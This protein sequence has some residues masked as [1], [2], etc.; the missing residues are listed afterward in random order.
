MSQIGT[1][2]SMTLASPLQRAVFNAASAARSA[3]VAANELESSG[4]S[5]PVS[6]GFDVEAYRFDPE[7]LFA[8]RPQWLPGVV[9]DTNLDA[10]AV[11]FAA[12]L[13]LVY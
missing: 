3:F 12:R 6:R 8:V 7:K 11:A 4:Q 2:A 5:L 9:E 13:A 10:V 1:R